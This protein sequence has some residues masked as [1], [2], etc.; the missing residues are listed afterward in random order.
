VEFGLL[1]VLE[2]RDGDR[3]VPVASARQ[4]VLLA[5]L[6]LRA[7]EAVTVDELAEA[8]WGDGRLPAQPRRVVQTY[9]T[10]LRK[11]VGGGLIRTRGAGYVLAVGPEAT[12]VGRFELLVTQAR[13]AGGRGDRQAEAG[14]L[15]QAL[16][17]WRGEPLADVPSAVLH[18]WVAARLGEQRLE[19]LQR[20]IDAGLALGRHAELVGE[21]RELTDAYPLREGFWAQLMVALS[22]CGRR[23]D[24][25]SA[26]GRARERLVEE[27]GIEPG[28]ELQRLQRAI[29]SGDAA[30]GVGAGPGRA[31][32]VV[33]PAQLPVDVADFVGREGLV[34]QLVGLL[35]DERT[36]P[37]VALSGPPGVGKTALAVHAAHR[38]AGQFADGQLYVDLQG[39]TAGLRPLAPLEVLGRFLRALGVDPAGIPAGLEEASAA[40]RSQAAG[41]RLLVVADNAAGA[42][43]LAPLLPAGP[44]CGVLVTSRGVLSAL[45]G[46][47]HL[48]LEVLEQAEATELLRRVAG[49]QRLDADPRAA[50]ELVGWCGRLPLALRIAGARLAARPAWPVRALAERLADAY[51]RLDEL[52]L[53]E[54]GMRASFQVSYQQLSDSPEGLDRAAA[55][56]F[57]LLGLLDG[58]EV[59]VPV[60]ARLLDAP[61]QAAE[62]ALERLA[63]AH[64][65]ETPAPGRYRLHDLLRLYARELALEQHPEPTRATAIGR[66]LGFY[67]ATTWQTLRLLRPGDYRLARADQRWRKGGLEFAD[68]R[69]ALGWLEA[70]RANLLAAVEQAAEQAAGPGV[71]AELAIQLAEALFGFFWVRGHW[72]DSAR[73]SLIAL[74]VARRLGDRVGE[75]QAN[76]DLGNM[77]WKQGRYDQ[78][79]ARHQESLAIWRELGDRWGQA[80]SLNGLGLVHQWQGRYERALARHQ[81][82]LAIRREL[83]D[84]RGQAG[85]ML[86]LGIVYGRLGRYDEALACLRESLALD[87]ELGDRWGQSGSLL[88]LGELHERQ[89][90]YEEAQS[91]QQESLA[92]ERELGDRHSQAYS[93]RCLG[94]LHQRQGRADQALADL[95][96]SLALSREL[97]DPYG[98]AATLRELGVT[99]RG[100]GRPEPAR[101]HWLG[102][103]AIFE[104]LGTVDADHV[105]GLLAEL[106]THASR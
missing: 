104:R 38:V 60:A 3:V 18:H 76:S 67:A 46:A 78:A 73:V 101:A 95:E 10:R 42:A 32:A 88:W 89:G 86:N 79:L 14:L 72:D 80:A 77:C 68:D 70:E 37:I 55:E 65:L 4:R 56:A 48:H 61:E 30:L 20:R 5:C 62:R 74:G 17:L 81:E 23:A 26:F 22:R 87:R 21:L 33:R 59:G 99:L 28:A 29:L 9:V 31:V 40:F 27:L 97:G 43:Q 69:A 85:S 75:A 51:G 11:L 49:P 98:E 105:R 7:G 93:L 1:G 45:H 102:A 71:P 96:E 44:G 6:L 16:G 82:S 54:I 94:V 2:V 50:A 52:E 57:G 91:C 64:L 13:V 34:D 15:G 41:R 12:D 84:R 47:R 66:A 39:A 103:L 53:A 92:I 8:I 83:G 106:P 36:V 35:D 19:A 90:R 100:L 58:P 63:D 25:L 24:A